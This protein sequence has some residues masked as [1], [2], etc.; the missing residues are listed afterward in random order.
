[1]FSFFRMPGFEKG[2]E[3][4]IHIGLYAG[5]IAWVFTSIVMMIWSLQGFLITGG[6]PI[7]FVVFSASQVVFWAS[8]IYY[9]KKFGC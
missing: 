4:S 3:R 6:L 9:K 2:D 5:R 7:Q 1:M 8:Y